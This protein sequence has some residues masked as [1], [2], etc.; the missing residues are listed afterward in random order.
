MK[1]IRIGD[2]VKVDDHLILADGAKSRIS[3]ISYVHEQGLFNLHTF[4]GEIV[5]DGVQA[6]TYTEAIDSCLAHAL[7]APLR[8]A[9]LIC[10]DWFSQLVLD[11]LKSFA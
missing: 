7:M 1:D 6:T 4:H 5:V 2:E 8:A 11:E 3:L 9:H 10:I